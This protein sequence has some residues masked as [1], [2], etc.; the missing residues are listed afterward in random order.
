MSK[1]RL[2]PRP[3]FARDAAAN[4]SATCLGIRIEQAVHCSLFVRCAV[5]FFLIPDSI[6]D[7][8]TNINQKDIKVVDSATDCD[9]TP[10][11]SGSNS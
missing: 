3:Y 10:L 8:L 1:L 4:R 5:F 9:Y 6:Q 2:W 11:S 7:G